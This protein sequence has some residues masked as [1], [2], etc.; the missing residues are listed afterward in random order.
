M[1]YEKKWIVSCAASVIAAGLLFFA[2]PSSAAT[3]IALPSEPPRTIA[4][5]G[6]GEVKAMPD[7]AAVSAGA[8][9]QA[10]T[11]S[12]AVTANSA[13]MSR[14]FGTLAAL[15][16]PRT[17]IATAGFALEPQY[18]P[19]SEKNPQ[20]RVIVGYEVSNNISVTLDDVTRAGGVL[21]ALID[22]GVNQSAGVAFNI[23]N[24]KPLLDQA[25]ELAGKD[26][27]R[28]AQIYARAVGATLG[29]VRSIHEG[30]GRESSG[31]EVE[32]VVVT[33]GRAPTPI[34][35]G[36][37]SVSATVTVEWAVK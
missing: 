9:T 26:A 14:A 31:G 16:I 23:K 32:T 29:P 12:D 25:R 10:R 36:E 2:R 15:G 8:V 5:T 24:P 22:A 34:A 21:D 27:L 37:Q 33:G 20:P 30:Y 4:M 13:I 3:T 7:Q 28:R 19:Q 1:R 18:P 35:A 11:A 17:S 6:E